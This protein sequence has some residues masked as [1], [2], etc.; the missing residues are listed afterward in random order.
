VKA[1]LSFLV[2]L[3]SLATLAY[4]LGAATVYFKLFP[5]PELNK[6]IYEVL[7][8]ARYW[9]NDLGIEP[10]RYLVSSHKS[11]G[12]DLQMEPGQLASGLR[13]VVGYFYD[14]PTLNG[15]ILIDEEG[16]K[17]HFWPVDREAIA[18]KAPSAFETYRH[19]FLHGFEALPDGS[20]VVNFDGGSVLA[21]LDACGEV[22]WAVEGAY[23]HV[24]EL[25][26][27]GTLWV[28]GGPN[29]AE[30]KNAFSQI[31]PDDG[32][33]IRTIGLD[34]EMERIGRGI[35]FIRDAGDMFHLNDVE[36]LD[37]SI[38]PAF[39]LFEAGDVMLSLRNVNLV[40]VLDAQDLHIKWW[41]H[42]P[43]HRQHDPDFLPNGRISVFDNNMDGGVS[44]IIEI[45][46]VTRETETVFEGSPNQ[47]FYTRIRGKHQL[48]D[49]G[50]IFIAESQAGRAFEVTRNGEVV[51][52]YQNRFDE[53]RNLL[54][55]DAILLPPDFFAPDALQCSDRHS[56][57]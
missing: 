10:T 35:F 53:D 47:P 3:V 43:W 49:N 26:S 24:A 13:V 2:F 29:T 30:D 56:R 37:P 41:Q 33:T 12:G 42:G 19:S 4:S 16:R 1:Y 17:L 31:D 9:K 25:A 50:N 48:L 21:R 46:S 51:W 15:A 38:A 22:L 55:S 27:D 11:R 54:V 23:H 57:E 5:Y 45:D 7:D 44:R 18:E 52:E 40:V 14:Q 6:S 20:I 36:M 28:L 34:Q 8:F 32:T 39:P